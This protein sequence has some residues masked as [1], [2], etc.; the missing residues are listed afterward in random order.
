MN[1]LGYSEARLEILLY[2]LKKLHQVTDLQV[3]TAR[4]AKKQEP[5][6][7]SQDNECFAK[8]VIE[9]DLRRHLRKK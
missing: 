2:E 3:A 7:E 5:R 1:T 9:F 6:D 4:N 8:D